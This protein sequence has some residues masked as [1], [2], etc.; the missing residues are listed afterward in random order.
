MVVVVVVVTAP[1][2]EIGVAV[3]VDVVVTGIP[4]MTVPDTLPAYGIIV[5]VVVPG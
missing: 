1:G 4:I 2:V 3:V 5:T